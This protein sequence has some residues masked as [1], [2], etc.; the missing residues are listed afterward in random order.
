MIEFKQSE[1]DFL[2]SLE[3][4]RI[5]TSHNDIPH[6]KPVSFVKINNSIII[7]TD[8]DTRTYTNIKFNRNVGIVIDIY[9]SGN[10]KAVCIQGK[11]EIIENGEEFKKIYEIFF[12]KFQW[13]RDDPWNENEAPFL[14]IVPTT[15]I[16]WGL[17]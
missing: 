1:I 10:H 7:A 12:K 5:A 9:K 4:A 3:E 16:S 8:Y 11:A 2:N 17:D 15:K 6:V 14:K 13:V